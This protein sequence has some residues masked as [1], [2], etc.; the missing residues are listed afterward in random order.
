MIIIIFV[1]ESNQYL[2]RIWIFIEIDFI[3]T[4]RITFHLFFERA[5]REPMP[6]HGGLFQSFQTL[7]NYFFGKILVRN[8]VLT[9]RIEVH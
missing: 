6:K 1:A 9:M 3:M 5:N 4:I 8:L 7:S 2:F